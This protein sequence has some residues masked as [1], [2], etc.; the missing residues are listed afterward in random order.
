MSVTG[1]PD[2]NFIKDEF[3]FNAVYAHGLLPLT[4]GIDGNDYVAIDH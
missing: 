4:N 2:R 1:N 3:G